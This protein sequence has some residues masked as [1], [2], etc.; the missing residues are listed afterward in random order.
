MVQ[1]YEY[2]E[3]DMYNWIPSH[4]WEKLHIIPD[5]SDSLGFT[6]TKPLVVLDHGIFDITMPCVLPE[7][8]GCYS[9]LYADYYLCS[10]KQGYENLTR[11]G[12]KAFYTGSAFSDF[13]Y[14][15]EN[16]D[17]DLLVYVPD[18]GLGSL[19]FDE[20]VSH[21]TLI[22]IAKIEECSH[23]VTSA[24][25]EDNRTGY[26][27]PVYSDRRKDIDGHRA[28]CKALLNKAKV[29][30]TKTQSTFQIVAKSMG[31]KVI[32]CEVSL[33]TLVDG[34]CRERILEVMDGIIS[35]RC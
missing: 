23:I 17:R 15:E 10:T 27:N 22:D 21:S 32:G 1:V 20:V 9:L 28:K 4:Y 7:K 19:Y 25:A 16:E 11:L 13:V 3:F 14:S 29:V 26:L 31:V 35:G 12:K 5:D 30:Y 24:I 34:K 2:P 18:H 33:E 6:P 8:R